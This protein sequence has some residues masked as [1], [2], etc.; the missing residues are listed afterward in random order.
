MK[1]IGESPTFSFL[2]LPTY[3]PAMVP[4]VLGLFLFLLKLS[5]VSF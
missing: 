5:D 3:Y 2:G 4:C 1:Q